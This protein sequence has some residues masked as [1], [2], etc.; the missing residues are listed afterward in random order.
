M[1]RRS[2][3][4]GRGPSLFALPILLGRQSG[5]GFP[6]GPYSLS[7]I[8]RRDFACTHR[9]ALSS[10]QEPSADLLTPPLPLPPAPNPI[11]RGLRIDSGSLIPLGHWRPHP[12]CGISCVS[13]LRRHVPRRGVARLVSF[14]TS[15]W[16][17]SPA[18]RGRRALIKY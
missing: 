15:T 7:F 4:S 18:L 17:P 9:A 1:R 11:I 13:R 2:P 6:G 8:N 14:S 3:W 5:A 12:G 10:I 16:N